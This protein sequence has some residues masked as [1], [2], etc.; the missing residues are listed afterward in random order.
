MIKEIKEKPT[1]ILFPDKPADAI[2]NTDRQKALDIIDE[3]ETLAKAS[4]LGIQ[5]FYYTLHAPHELLLIFI[6]LTA[7]MLGRCI[8]LVRKDEQTFRYFDPLLGAVVGLVLYVVVKAGV[9]VLVDTRSGNGMSTDLNPF[10]VAFMGLVAGLRTDQAIIRV[11]S[12]ADN[13]LA[14]PTAGKARYGIGLAKLMNDTGRTRDQWLKQYP[15]DEAEFNMWIEGRKPMPEERQAAMA[16]WLG[17]STS[18]IFSDLPPPQAQPAAETN[19]P[20]AKDT[21]AGTEEKPRP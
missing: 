13:W 3:I 12:V 18:E 20:E 7:G 15:A 17:K 5:P 1:D 19:G 11:Y 16:L 10:L 4:I 9:I 14:S 8:E 6:V 2:T 21:K